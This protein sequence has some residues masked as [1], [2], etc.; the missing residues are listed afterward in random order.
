MSKR[1][2]LLGTVIALAVLPVV[3]VAGL[4]A[5]IDSGA[6]RAFAVRTVVD[7]VSG[8]GETLTIEGHDG[9]LLSDLQLRGITMA[10][11][12]GAWLRAASVTLRWRPS[13]LL[14]GTLALDA[15]IVEDLEVLRPPATG[16]E[17]D[18][19][20][21]PGADAPFTL[22]RLPFEAVLGNL[23]VTRVSLGEPVLGT[24]AAFRVTG[25]AGTRDRE[26][27]D[28]RLMIERTD[29]VSGKLD[30][31]AT[32][33][34][35]DGRL[36]LSV[37]LSEP[38]GGLAARLLALPDLP[39][40][41]LAIQGDGSLTRWLGSLSADLEGLV[42]VDAGLGLT[43]VGDG[44]RATIDGK[45]EP[46]SAPAAAPD[47]GTAA[48]IAGLTEG[49]VTFSADLTAREAARVD[50]ADL[51]LESPALRIAASGQLDLDGGSLDADADLDLRRPG[52]LQ[53]VLAPL[54]LAPLDLTGAQV[55]VR[56]SGGL[57]RPEVALTLEARGLAGPD[58]AAEQITARVALTPSDTATAGSVRASGKVSGLAMA[59]GALT[60]A[61]LGPDL[62]WSLDGAL[63]LERWQ[64][65]I[66]SAAVQAAQ[67]DIGASGIIDLN[68]GDFALDSKMDINDLN[69]LSELAGLSLGGRTTLAATV[70]GRDFGQDL[71]LRMTGQTA[72][73]ALGEPLVSALLG[74][75]PRYAA[76]LTLAGGA[77]LAVRALRIESQAVR[78]AGDLDLDLDS[79]LA[80][81]N[82]KARVGR[83]APWL[84]FAG[85]GGDGRLEASATLTGADGRQG[86][87]LDA[88]L[89]A[90][91]L[92]AAGATTTLDTA[93]LSLE[94]ADVTGLRADRLD[95]ALSALAA[96]SATLESL[97]IRGHGGLEGFDFTLTAAGQAVT[98]FDLDAKGRV[99]RTDEGLALRLAALDGRVLERTLAVRPG[100]EL[101]RGNGATSLDNLD[102]TLGPARVRGQAR[103]S[104]Q[105][106]DAQVAISGLALELLA[107][108]APDLPAN[109]TAEGTLRLAGSP[110]D[111][112]GT[113]E[114]AIRDLTVTDAAGVP[115]LNAELTAE[116]RAA[117]LG[118]DLT[119]AGFAGQPAT[120]TAD[121]PLRLD[122]DRF[123][124]GLDPNAP[125]SGELQWQG[126]L[127][128]L[129]ALAPVGD[130]I[131]S[132]PA[133]LALRA[134]GSLGDPRL[135]GALTL[136]GAR[137]ET[138]ESGTV[139]DDLALTLVLE[140]ET[141]TLAR[142]EASDGAKGRLTG[143]GS[144]AI[145]VERG[146]PFAFD[147][148]LEDFAAPRRDDLRAVQNG[149]LTIAGSADRVELT[150][151][152]TVAPVEVRISSGLP[153][154]VVD[155]QVVEVNHAAVGK[156]PPVEETGAAGGPAIA[157]DLRI[158]LPKRVA[159]RGLGLE[160]EWGGA[161]SVRGDSSAPAIDGKLSVI[162]GQLS[163]LGRVFGLTRG[164]I[165]LA[166]G[167]EIDPD[168]D[169]EARYTRGDL[170]ARVLVTGR[171]SKPELT[172][173]SVPELPRDEILSRVLFDKGT[174]ELG[175]FEAVQLAEAVA[176]ISTGNSGSAGVLDLARQTLGLDVL[177][178]ESGDG[179]NAGPSVS[180]GRY[181]ADGVFVGVRQGVRQD[182]RP[183]TGSLGV[184][185]ELTPNISVTSDVGQSGESDLGVQFRW[186]Y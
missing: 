44:L 50:L 114:I 179:E 57:Q 155:L 110:N 123:A 176:G 124:P 65:E 40:V 87:D 134:G 165:T 60:G 163:L 77:S 140:G 2:A 26:R 51:T 183:G 144:L 63:D 83:L 130:P 157:L 88:E 59:P 8:P 58:L 74:P 49:G 160:S 184:E 33:A 5:W 154:D 22:P 53:P 173:T 169:I 41:D 69:S 7:S 31:D 109:G 4:L 126:D 135:S 168:L 32:Y 34:P 106:L 167:S 131:A 105:A 71:A 127:R 9:A 164:S 38:A 25:S 116:W 66:A 174:G 121:L 15:V 112:E 39:P 3:A 113:A 149:T 122:P 172:L 42:T 166:S 98:D 100:L 47:T 11:P 79:G 138:L 28:S 84:A 182:A 82:L 96:G 153:P 68:R 29:G 92:T 111:P 180:A 148:T 137:Y 75:A 178:V 162:R 89:R 151:A 55:S 125:I 185:V 181:V 141:A 91:T 108:L 21:D 158:D 14:G 94:A 36:A 90:L 136:E 37:T 119:V 20:A 18:P 80:D 171:A 186:D 97:R 70:E 145:A 146:F 142:L 150:G 67:L 101:R 107:A 52:V 45:A 115:P 118:L 85:L 35:A 61:L 128:E 1:E 175:T 30:A 99:A 103:L 117:R 102:L 177:R 24:P 156:A 16:P 43:R 27:L 133:R 76:D 12:D 6:G 86:L 56:L 13:A 147:L 170:T 17:V 81:G 10:D 23:T 152:L 78:L 120:L 48:L 72:G 143:S 64:A 62:T 139:L 129:A 73:L 161:F 95:L 93:S 46:A 19:E 132:G 54:D 104:K 159:V